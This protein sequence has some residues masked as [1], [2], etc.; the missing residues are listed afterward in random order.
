MGRS[1]D[2]SIGGSEDRFP[3]TARAYRHDLCGRVRRPGSPTAPRMW[4]RPLRPRSRCPSGG[5]IVRL[6][7]SVGN[8][9]TAMLLSRPRP[10]SA[11][12]PF[13]GVQ[14][15]APGPGGGAQPGGASA[16]SAALQSGHMEDVMALTDLSQATEEQRVGLIRILANQVGNSRV[17]ATGC[18]SCG[19]LF[20]GSGADRGQRQS[21]RVAELRHRFPGTV[22]T[23]SRDRLLWEANSPTRFGSVASPTSTRTTHMSRTARRSSGSA[24][25]RDRSHSPLTS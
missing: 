20:S 6:Q 14:R 7:R 16:I 11:R 17:R 19:R 21:H 12:A 4:F 1:I 25:S 2:C 23:C 3:F 13:P 22:G 24:T 10:M 8:R 15:Q 9:A 5:Y 18:G